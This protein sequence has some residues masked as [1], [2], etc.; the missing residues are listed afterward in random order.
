MM[1]FPCFAVYP[2]GNVRRDAPSFFTQ[3]SSQVNNGLRDADNQ[4]QFGN[5]R[6]RAV[7]L[8]SEFWVGVNVATKRGNVCVLGAQR[9]WKVHDASR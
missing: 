9:V 8:E 4:V 5:E 3:G 1:L 6:R 7:F 2:A